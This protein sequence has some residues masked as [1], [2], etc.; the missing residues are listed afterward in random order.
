MAIRQLQIGLVFLSGLA[1][2]SFTISHEKADTEQLIYDVRNAFVTAK[3]EMPSHLL[4]D[5]H[6]YVNTA[7]EETMHNRVRHRVVLVVKIN[8]LKT[9]RTLLVT[10]NKARV[11]VLAASVMTG[12]VIAEAKFTATAY[13]WSDHSS[14]DE[15]SRGISS[16]IIN[17][18]KLDTRTRKTFMSSL[19]AL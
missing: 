18:F 7:I 8:D 2:M 15:L 14:L 13:G 9:Y 11:S 16:Q 6:H 17:E 4:Q 5:I 12:D 19:N 1:L 3:A 10:K